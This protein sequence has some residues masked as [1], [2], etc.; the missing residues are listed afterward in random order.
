MRFVNISL[1][2]LFC[3]LFIG[4]TNLSA[5][6][7]NE[8][9]E[10]PADSKLLYSLFLIGDAGDDTIN[11]MPVLRQLQLQLQKSDPHK[12]GIIFLGDNIYPK[13]LHKKKSEYRAEDELRLNAQLNIVKDFEGEVVF[14]SGNHDWKKYGDGGLKA[15]KRQ[16]N[17]IEDYLDR[18]DVF[19]PAN[20]CPGPEVVQLTPGLV[21]IVIDTQWWLHQYEK[22][23]GLKDD[24]QCR[25]E[26]ELM[27]L[28]KDLLKKYRH[29]HIIVAGHH[30]LYS[31][32]VHGGF[33]QAKDHLFPLTHVNES[34]Y[35]PLP[36]VGS[37]YPFYR[38][39]IGHNQDLAHPAYRDMAT[40]ISDA[41]LEYE[42]ILYVA[43][44]EHNLQ[45]HHKNTL[46]H[47]ISGSGS[48]TSYLNPNPNLKFGAQ[49]RGYSRILYFD[50]GEI[51]LEFYT[52]HSETKSV[53]L[54]FRKKLY[55]KEVIGIRSITSPEKKSYKGQMATVTPDTSFAASEFKRTFWGNLNRDVWITPLTVPYL[56][57]HYEKGGLT[58]VKKGGGQ[59]TISLRMLG[60]DGKEY[61]LRGIKK[62]ARFLVEK[63]LRGTITQDII[64]DGMAGSHPYASVAIPPLSE[65]AGVY[66][67]NPQLV[68]V[69]KDSIL[70]DYI[71]E[72]GGMF[73]LFEERPDDDMS[74][75]SYFGHSK[76]V[77]SYTSAI[78]K[79]QAEYDHVVD[80]DYNVTARLFDMAIGDWDR[81]DDQ[82][83]W[84][85]FKTDEKVYYRAIPRDRDQ[86]FFKFDG[87]FP[88]ISNRKW[89]LRKFQP[90][91]EEVRDIAGLNFNARYF[92][93]AFL[94]EASKDDWIRNA[95][96]LKANLTD[97]VIEQA[98]HS[99][100]PEG[101]EI[102]GAEI[103]TTLKARRDNL[104]EIAEQYYT[105]LA[106]TVSIP[107]TLKADFF[108][109][110]RQA[111]GG[112]EVNIYPRKHGKKVKTQRYYHRIFHRDETD[113][114]Q[115]YGLDGKDEYQ[116]KGTGDK[117]ILV[118]I[119]AG[120]EKDKIEDNA[121][122]SGLKKYTFVYD[123]EGKNDVLTGPDTKMK[124]VANTEAYDY[125][126]KEFVYN[127]LL[128]LLS[129]GYNADDGFYIGPGFK[130]TAH[131]FKKQPYKYYHKVLANR[132]YFIN[133]YNFYYNFDYTELF[134]PFDLEG[135][136]RIN[137]PDIYQYYGGVAGSDV[138]FDSDEYNVKMNDYHLNFNLKLTSDDETQKVRFGLVYRHVNFD[139]LPDYVNTE[140]QTQSQNFLAPGVE[141]RYENLSN[142]I[143]PYRGI[144]FYTRLL[145]N[146]SLDN[147]KVNYLHLNTAFSLYQ[148][149]NISSKQ[150]TLALRSAYVNNFGDYAFFQSNFVDGQKN[151]RGVRRNRYSA[152]SYFYQNVDLRL[153]LLKVPNYVAPFD[154]GVMG[155]FDL[156]RMWQADG[157]KDKW[158]NSYGFG[159]FISIL[160][161]FMLK[162]TYSLSEQDEL[163]VVGTRFLF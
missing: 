104:P 6:D 139:A 97:E 105:I 144:K 148:P 146:H 101:F 162:A 122:V 163:M 55:Q 42:D 67:P 115:L 106:K 20:G 48:K 16:A 63:E 30:P 156:I 53:P 29:Q 9:D 17:Y 26:D 37:I 137:L 27:V 131:G 1:L 77:R 151:F 38:K 49:Q 125:D 123:S 81:H 10:L 65:A 161:A 75:A 158:H 78:E 124:T 32:G 143:H 72:F 12:S 99:L 107:G 70:G 46:H 51:W 62:N 36:V 98:I 155:H 21:L 33:F 59:Q 149:I 88:S 43:G 35:I 54:A 138:D 108:E 159:T 157:I 129:L 8:K 95:E 14:I 31:N 18:K 113:E 93:R 34:A 133:G 140:W 50:N 119:I 117:S 136:V 134:G 120:P 44:H 39:F 132:A 150:T 84:A 61:T 80:M 130:Y 109:I 116:L 58:P 91:D 126:R 45:Y 135:N 23:S 90:F 100:P 47:V 25:N 94:T 13:G 69:P 110:I 68:Y 74:D 147:R 73:C 82:W 7:D 152:K 112:V 87:L 114:I 103:I 41:M 19:L 79:M 118:R 127:N 85:T 111:D 154:W 86:A 40:Q 160:D 153:S 145:W 128:P 66:H 22:S 102:N 89:L 5:Q 4:L 56:D 57:I 15:V 76:K 71:D 83:R 24:C 28:F 2:A 92:D 60:G 52:I 11:S 142:V 141:Y 121:R 96:Q 64:Y 3:V